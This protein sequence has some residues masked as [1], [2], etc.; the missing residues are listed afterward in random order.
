MIVHLNG[1]LVPRDEARISPL[2]RGFIL[3]EG[4]YE[5]LRAIAWDA[6]AS[7]TRVVGIDRHIR[8]L[9]RGLSGAGISC[10]VSA[11]HEM[12]RDLLVANGLRDAFVYWQ[13]TGGTPG[14]NDPPRHR[15]PPGNLKPTVFGYC[16]PQPALASLTGPMEKRVL[17]CRDP[18]WELGWLKSTSLMGNVWVARQAA[19]KGFDEAILIRGGD[20]HGRGGVVSEGLATNV[21]LVISTKHDG[22]EIVTPSLESAPML[23]GVTRDLMLELAPDIRERIVR[24]EELESAIEVMMLG[25]TTYVSAVVEI[26][27]R[28]VGDG[29]AGPMTR[30]L[31]SR[32]MSCYR[33]GRDVASA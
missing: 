10:D 31:F 18:R 9:E 28:R 25:T 29:R 3:G 15:V 27:G 33:Q 1:K 26:N 11:L 14:P 17:A 5:G 13:V 20:E 32:L 6:H 4:V 19:E 12:S 8:R 24:Q 22:V 16:N 7:G 2:D 23:R 30:E 21:V